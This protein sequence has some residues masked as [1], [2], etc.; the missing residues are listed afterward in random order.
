MSTILDLL[1]DFVPRL[2]LC[3][4]FYRE[5]QYASKFLTS[6]NARINK[7][8]IQEKNTHTHKTQNTKK[9]RK[10]QRKRMHSHW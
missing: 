7:V 4:V 5:Y 8:T 2:V 6:C 1:L 9:E 3:F 10:K